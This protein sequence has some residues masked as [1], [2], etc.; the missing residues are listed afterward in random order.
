MPN[1]TLPLVRS[2]DR[3]TR[4]VD[5]AKVDDAKLTVQRC[6]RAG[7][8]RELR[9]PEMPDS[10]LLTADGPSVTTTVC[11]SPAM[12][13]QMANTMLTDEERAHIRVPATSEAR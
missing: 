6:D 10:I 11:L 13:V 4:L 5:V 3:H 12:L 8:A 9:Q 1:N 7:L 2:G